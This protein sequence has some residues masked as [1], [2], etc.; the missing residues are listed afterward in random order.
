MKR[1]FF[2]NTKN[3]SSHVLKIS[4][5]SLI[6]STREITDLFNKFDKIYLVFISKKVNILYILKAAFAE[7]TGA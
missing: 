7:S 6:L 2:V 5:I 1:F 3:I 4:A